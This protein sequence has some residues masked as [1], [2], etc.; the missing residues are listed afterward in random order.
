[1]VLFAG[2]DIKVIIEDKVFSKA[3][4]PVLIP[5]VIAGYYAA[6]RERKS[7]QGK[8]ISIAALFSEAPSRPR[9]CPIIID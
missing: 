5:F 4:R 9:L 6:V 3:E 8:G 1:M 2:A 7:L